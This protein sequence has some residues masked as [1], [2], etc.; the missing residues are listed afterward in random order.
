M[1]IDY[2]D[3]QS[4]KEITTYDA[5]IGEKLNSEEVRKGRAQTLREL[6]EFDVKVEVDESEM[7]IT[8]NK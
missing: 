6:D 4:N 8:P 2:H 3:S 5:R 1:E 7:S